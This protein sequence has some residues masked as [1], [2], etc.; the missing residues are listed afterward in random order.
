MLICALA[1][2]KIVT[3]TQSSDLELRYSQKNQLFKE[4][5]EKTDITK[6]RFEPYLLSPTP[7]SQ[8]I[9]YMLL[10]TF[11]KKYFAN[12]FAR[13]FLKLPDGGTIGIDWD[14]GIPDPAA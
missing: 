7:L 3:Y 5:V 11:F 14:D 8:G 12:V 13:E 4:F 9:V 6:M 1:V 2:L 10:E